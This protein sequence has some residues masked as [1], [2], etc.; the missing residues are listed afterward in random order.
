MTAMTNVRFTRRSLLGGLG[1][2]GAAGLLAACGGA[3]PTATS[4]PK[5]T[6]APA[7]APTT[8][9][10]AKPAEPTKPAAAATTAPAAAAT[11]APAAAA[12]KPA[13]AATTAPAAAAPAA[14]VKPGTAIK[15]TTRVGSDAEV[16]AKTVQAFT[17]KT[18]ITAT[19]E[20]NPGEPEY[21]AKIAALH[22]TKQ[23]PDVIWAS[24]GG[25]TSFAFK[26]VMAE[27][28]PL[29]LGDKYD[30]E[31][32]VKA[33]LDSLRYN[34]KLY[35]LPWG[36]HPGNGGVL[37]NVD[38][39]AKAGLNVTDDPTSFNN[40]TWEQ[41]V[42]AGKKVTSGDTYGFM[43]GSDFLSITN[44]VNSFGG[45]F[46]DKE[47]KKLTMDTPE[48]KR[49]LQLIYDIYNTHKIAP[50]PD[51][52]LNTGELFAG[53]KLAMLHGG[54]GNQFSP[55]DKAIAGKFKWNVGLTPKGPA[56]KRGTALTINGQTIWSG[57]QQKEAAWQFVKY[58]MEPEQ[59]V[60][61]VLSGGSRPALRNKVLDN[62][63]LM[64]EMKAH[65]V[66]AESIKAAEPW[67]QPANYRWPEF[68]SAVRQV[69][70]NAWLGKENVDTAITNAKKQL[71]DILDKPPA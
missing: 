21:W 59:N 17:Q 47:G 54:Y 25:L 50:T 60:E 15:V 13:A 27:L 53:G 1:A 6:T 18:G 62:D 42:E 63:R 67:K 22:A 33:G 46:F 40:V 35:G 20:A 39:L 32:Y 7:A 61:L 30:M 31:D 65:K 5:P 26:G 12:T 14:P 66:F 45:D 56:G 34:G 69:F 48:F 49:G 28:D 23:A 58:L 36:G 8:A 44:F 41:I 68:D 64:K 70:A 43:P 52:K 38:L 4:A 16:M 10:A 19:H 55:G 24:T 3:A 71:Q 9:P 37:Y 2:L 11:V 51:P 29:I 57:S